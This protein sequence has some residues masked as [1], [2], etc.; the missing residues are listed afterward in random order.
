MNV[1]DP[2]AM[3]KPHTILAALTLMCLSSCDKVR[4][5]VD[6][7]GQK[8]TVPGSQVSQ[9]PKDVRELLP[10]RPGRIVLVDYYA[11]WCGPCRQL[12]PI[13]EKIAGENPSLIS[14]CKVNVDKF[15]GLAAQ[16]GVHGIPDVRIFVDGKRV[17]QF[18]GALPE[19][20]VRKRIDALAQ[21]L[22][23]L[24]PQDKVEG[25]TPKAAEPTSRPMP[26]DWMPPGVRRR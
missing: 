4:T 25:G 26:K 10:T 3:L 7:L 11:D 20:E 9:I 24:P 14:V 15:G 16:E 8:K 17:D 21:R 12:S 22:P 2:A 19:P 6:H 5:L 23:P 1:A 18:V 13:L